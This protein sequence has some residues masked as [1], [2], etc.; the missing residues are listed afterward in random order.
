MFRKNLALSK[1]GKT[2]LSQA[3]LNGSQQPN[4]VSMSGTS[5]V[6]DLPRQEQSSTWFC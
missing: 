3:I 6:V 4:S 5:K 2:S 1:S